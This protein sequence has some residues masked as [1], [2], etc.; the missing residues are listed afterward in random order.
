[1]TVFENELRLTKGNA[2]VYLL[3]ID[4]KKLMST[5]LLA[6]QPLHFSCPYQLSYLDAYINRAAARL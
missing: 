4:T 6:G 1:M 2:G 3:T 5:V